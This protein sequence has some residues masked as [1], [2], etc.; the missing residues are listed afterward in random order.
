MK[1]SF[2]LLL[3]LL[4][5]LAI[6]QDVVDSDAIVRALEP[7]EA[8]SEKPRTRGLSFGRGISVRVK[9]K[10]DLKVPFEYNSS[11]LAPAAAA[12]LTE[13]GNALQ[14]EALASY[15]F[16]IA[17]HTDASG[18]AAYNQQLS[19]A[20]ANSVKV[21]LIDRGIDPARI[22]SIGLGEE[23]LADPDRPNHASNRRVEIRN[24]GSAEEGTE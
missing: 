16:E 1:G 13:L 10:V 5:P 19:E 14:R 21:F 4:A 7:A 3:V 15:R 20:R 8:D 22:E 12:Q 6:A 17:G 24:L 9:S 11:E 18:P 2:A 23:Q